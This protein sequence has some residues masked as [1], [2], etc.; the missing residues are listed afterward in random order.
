MPLPTAFFSWTPSGDLDSTLAELVRYLPKLEDQLFHVY[1][2]KSMNTNTLADLAAAA[3]EVIHRLAK[4][5]AILNHEVGNF[6]NVIPAKDALRDLGAALHQTKVD[7]GAIAT[8]KGTAG[9]AKL[10]QQRALVCMAD[11][12]KTAALN[13]QKFLKFPVCM[14]PS[15]KTLAVVKAQMPLVAGHVAVRR[16]MIQ[17]FI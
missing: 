14:P 10:L 6:P 1:A 8:A 9:N 3:P 15:F 12:A 2:A 4:V 16:L 13:G 11:A 7:C 17:N 5:L